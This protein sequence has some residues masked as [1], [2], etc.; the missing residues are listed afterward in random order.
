MAYATPAPMPAITT[1]IRNLNELLFFI[2]DYLLQFEFPWNS[3]PG[4]FTVPA[5]FALLLDLDD[6]LIVSTPIGT[7]LWLDSGAWIEVSPFA[8]NRGCAIGNSSPAASCI[9]VPA[10]P[11][12]RPA[13][14]LAR[15][16]IC[17]CFA[18]VQESS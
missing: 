3:R 5:G 6:Q 10:I 13:T 4:H 1:N 16:V 9:R 17:F 7:F 14:A 2:F 12:S 15:T 8:S 18:G 11:Q